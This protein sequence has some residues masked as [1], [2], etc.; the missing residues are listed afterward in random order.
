MT[1]AE[2]ALTNPAAVPIIGRQPGRRSGRWSERL[3]GPIFAL[4][5]G[6]CVVAVSLIAVF[7]ILGG[8]PALSQIGPLDFLSGRRWTPS[9]TP[10]RFGLLPMIVGSLYTT[11]GAIAVGLPIGLLTAVFL[12]RSCPPRLY[13]LLKPGLNLLAGIPSVV[14]GFFGLAV[15]VPLFGNS[16]LTASFLLGLMILPTI[17]TLSESALR[18]VPVSYGEGALALGAGPWRTNYRV[19]LPAAKSGLVAAVG[20]ALGRAIGETMAVVMVAGN[21]ARLPDSL[22]DGVRTMTANIVLEM[23]YAAD[24][25]RQALIAT[26]VVLLVFIFGLNLSLSYLTRRRPWQH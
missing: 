18:A 26:G 6:I 7:L 11:A 12:A 21:Q 22:F 2:S 20:L 13:R 14:Y 23:G 5:A 9:D 3:A 16:I 15:L 17:I 10:A 19:I 1:T 24:L 4:V 8:L 25:H